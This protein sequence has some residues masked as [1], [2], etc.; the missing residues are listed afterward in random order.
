MYVCTYIY[1]CLCIYMYMYIYIL[2]NLFVLTGACNTGDTHTLNHPSGASLEETKSLWLKSAI[3]RWTHV[4]ANAI[5][6]HTTC[7]VN[8][9]HG[10]IQKEY[11]AGMLP[12]FVTP[13]NSSVYPVYTHRMFTKE[14]LTNLEANPALEVIL[15]S[16]K[17]L[18]QAFR[19]R[20]GFS[21]ADAL[22]WADGECAVAQVGSFRGSQ[23]RSTASTLLPSTGSTLLP[24][25][26]TIPFKTTGAGEWGGGEEGH[27]AGASLSA[28]VPGRH[29]FDASFQCLDTSA[30]I[31]GPSPWSVR[32]GGGGG[33]GGEGNEVVLSD[34]LSD[35]GGPLK[36]DACQ[37]CNEC[38]SMSS[39]GDFDNGNLLF[40]C[41]TC[42]EPFA[43]AVAVQPKEPL[44]LSCFG[45][46]TKIDPLYKT[47]LCQSWMKTGKC[48]YEIQ[49]GKR[50]SFAHGL[51]DLQCVLT[52]GSSSRSSAHANTLTATH[53]NTRQHTATGHNDNVPRSTALNRMSTS[54][55]Y[56]RDI[57][58]RWQQER[59]G[60][61]GENNV[62]ATKVQGSGAHFQGPFS[63]DGVAQNQLDLSQQRQIQ[64]Q[65]THMQQAGA[66]NVW[67]G[68]EEQQ[69][70]QQQIKA[71]KQQ[72][73]AQTQQQQQA[74]AK[75]AWSG[76]VGGNI[77]RCNDVSQ[78]MQHQHHSSHINP[79]FPPTNAPSMLSQTA[80]NLPS[81]SM[82]VT[83]GMT[84]TSRLSL[85]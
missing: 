65:I 58:Q 9:V 23:G 21:A 29:Q 42:W 64:Q 56:N 84:R 4:I 80:L 53:F 40:Y 57:Y 31:A 16:S 36:T 14:V 79:Y 63:K 25:R 5:N 43:R 41:A 85:L 39:L 17:G 20:A 67:S 2:H 1:I 33:G 15:R 11:S 55:S 71:V 46:C 37:K 66:R 45:A 22:K 81:A 35:L 13:G 73:R 19:F 70:Q 30:S 51:T 12:P 49:S 7:N 69:K 48:D 18:A 61:E 26:G 59:A 60:V 8:S 50:C 62:T 78:Q 10:V 82:P 74:S 72:T 76:A 28:I 54:T 44:G 3:V 47:M 24:G 75:G 38:G 52:D 6:Q 32:G 77:S 68:V 27:S 34:L 83:S